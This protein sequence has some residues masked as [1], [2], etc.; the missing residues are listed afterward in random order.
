MLIVIEDKIELPII[1]FFLLFERLEK[2][3]DAV[4]RKRIYREG[5]NY[6]E[7]TI[8]ALIGLFL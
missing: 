1:W 3:S 6:R 4:C 2:A 8:S 7:G 5:N